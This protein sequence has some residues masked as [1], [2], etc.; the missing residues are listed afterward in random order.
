MTITWL[1]RVCV[2]G[3]LIW[4]LEAMPTLK[5]CLPGSKT[6]VSDTCALCCGLCPAGFSWP[7]CWLPLV[8]Q[9]QTFW[10]GG[11]HNWS[12]FPSDF[13][14]PLVFCLFVFNI[15]R[16]GWKLLHPIVT[17][18][19]VPHG[20]KRSH[21]DLVFHTLLLKVLLHGKL[22]VCSMTPRGSFSATRKVLST[23][24]LGNLTCL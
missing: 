5:S 24:L 10:G 1:L 23:V 18:T 9:K 8:A 12:S 14:S 7:G 20:F 13:F 4:K 15:S 19:P 21:N 6:Q 2:V 11:G 16:C 17:G 22:N 3:S